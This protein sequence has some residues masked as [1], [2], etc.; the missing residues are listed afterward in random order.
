MKMATL[1]ISGIERID[2]WKGQDKKKLVEF[3]KYHISG[4]LKSAKKEVKDIVEGN[5]TIIENLDVDSAQK[6][7]S[8]LQAMGVKV[9]VDIK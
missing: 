7:Q 2:D 9:D 3:L 1:K 4:G 5:P 6:L 8:I